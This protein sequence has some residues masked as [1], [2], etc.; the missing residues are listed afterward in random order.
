MKS[1]VYEKIGT[2]IFVTLSQFQWS[3]RGNSSLYNPSVYNP[4]LYNP[5][6]YNPSV[7]NPSLYNPSLYNIHK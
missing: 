7:Y 3:I 1:P 5:S 6:V 4:S 2:L